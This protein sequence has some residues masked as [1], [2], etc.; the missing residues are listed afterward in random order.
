MTP[1]RSDGE[2]RSTSPTS[3]ASAIGSLG[4]QVLRFE[5]GWWPGRGG[6]DRAIRDSLG[7][8]PTRY[9]QVLNQAIDS[10]G[11]WSIDPALVHRLRRCR[12]RQRAARPGR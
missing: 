3:D 12:A 6:K 1:D 9:F 4:E 7:I 11:S 10:P 8:S 2:A 5:R